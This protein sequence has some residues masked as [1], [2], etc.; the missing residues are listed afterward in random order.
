MSLISGSIKDVLSI[1]IK[2][3]HDG[4]TDQFSRIFMVKMFLISSLVMSIEFFNDTVSCIVAEQESMS[5]EFVHSACWIQ[6]F[7]IYEELR[8]QSRETSYYGKND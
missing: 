4:C 8:Y 2:Y 1:K 3:R 5:K 7:Y 6:G